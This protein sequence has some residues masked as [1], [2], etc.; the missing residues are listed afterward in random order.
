MKKQIEIKSKKPRLAYVGMDKKTVAEAVPTQVIEVVYPHKAEAPK[1]DEA[2]KLFEQGQLGTGK[3]QKIS[4]FPKNRLIWT[5]DNL[6]ALKT[7]L[8]E[9]D[10]VS[11]EYKYR[12]KIDL[13]YIDPPFM[14]QNDFVAEN[15]I[16]IEVDEEEG[17]MSV[18][19]PTIIETIA[20]KDTWQ[21]GLDGFL[22]MMR[23]R[24]VLMKELLSPTG[25]IYVHLDWHTV[26]YVKVLMDEIFGYDLFQREIVWNF[27]NVSGFKSIAPNWIR[28]HEIILFYGKTADINFEKQ[29][30][31]Y[32]EK[33]LENFNKTDEQGRK[34]WQWNSTTRR[35]LDDYLKK[36]GIPISDVWDIKY[37]NNMSVERTG[38]PTQKPVELLRRI[39]RASCPKKRNRS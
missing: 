11:G 38:Y 15:S 22:Q 29:F 9:K 21:N 35:Y 19:E 23:E 4:Q 28:A 32:S 14:V 33:Y 39:I 31:P 30:E 24:L 6:V 20:Y 26:H 16:N 12:N 37:E 34:Y 17:V 7:L 13:I 3:I 27:Q 5:N 10:S 36:S 1:E 8:D 2:A 25:S 18:K